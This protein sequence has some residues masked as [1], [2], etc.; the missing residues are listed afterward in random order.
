MYMYMIAK[1]T[2]L[3][4]GT[5]KVHSSIYKQYRLNTDSTS[6]S[7]S[8]K[9][10]MTMWLCSRHTSACNIFEIFISNRHTGRIVSVVTNTASQQHEHRGR[11]RSLSL[12]NRRHVRELV[13]PINCSLYNLISQFKV[14]RSNVRCV[15]ELMS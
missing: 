8:A 10:H 3:Y 1:K 2:T 11:S 9:V 12:Y 15:S 7:S 14:K 6:P 13:E 5:N 4:D